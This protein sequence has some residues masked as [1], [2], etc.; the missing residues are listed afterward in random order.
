M[1]PLDERLRNLKLIRPPALYTFLEQC[2]DQ[3]TSLQIQVRCLQKANAELVD[4]L[5]ELMWIREREHMD[6]PF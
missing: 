5:N 2:A 6:V 4:T 1:K 3:A